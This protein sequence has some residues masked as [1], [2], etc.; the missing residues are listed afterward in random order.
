MHLDL[1]Y[2]STSHSAQ[3]PTSDRVLYNLEA[4]S[5]TTQRDVYYVGVSRA[6]HETVVFTENES[7]LMDKVDREDGKTAALDIGLESTRLWRQKEATAA[8]EMKP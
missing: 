3:G 8:M 4:F 7:K 1:A 5:R 2:A 6:R